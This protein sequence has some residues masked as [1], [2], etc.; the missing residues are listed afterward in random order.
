M[1]LNAK[2]ADHHLTRHACIYIRQSTMAQVRF[3]QE[4]TERQY[5]LAD[6]AKSLGW[7][8]EQIRILDGDL[9]QSG[10]QTTKRDDFKTLVTDVAMGQ[11][12]AIF[13]LE[14]SRLARS[15][16]DWHRLLELCAITK[17]LVFDGDGCYDP[18][19][20]NDSLVLGMKGTFAQAELHIIRARL[21]GG[22]L[23]K[24]HKGELRFPLPVGLVFDGDKIVLDPDQEVQGAVRAAF[25]LFEQ[26][27]SAYGV[28]QRFHQLGLL[29]PRR[30]YGGVWNGKLIWGRLTHSR[31]LGVLTN[32]SY[33]GTYVFGRYQ[34]CKKIGPAGEISTQSRQMPQDQ[35]RVVIPDHHPGYITWAQFLANRSHL[36]A[37]RTNSEV[38][39]GPAREGLCLLQGVLL[40]GICG[41]RLSTRY[42]GNGG[43]YP[44]YDCN[45]RSRD[46]SPLRHCMS[47]PAKPL[48]DAIAARLLTAVTPLTIK[49]ALEALNNLEVR[50]KTISAQWRR[51]I[52]RARYEA[53]LAER[54]YEESDPS[55]RLVAATLEK[56]WNDA[57]Q[58]VIELEAELA[59]FERQSMRSVTAEQ[60]QQILRLGRDF[61]RLWKAPTT[62]ARDR[63]RILRLLIRD[64]TVSKA[65]QPKLL[66]LQ[67]CW[68]GG[69]TET[70]EVQQRPSYPDV[71]RYPDAFVAKIR[72]MAERYDDTEIVARLKAEGLTSSTGKLFTASMISWTRYKHRISR[73]LLPDGTLNVRQVRARYGVSLWVV[74]Y[75]I[76][77]G[78]VSATQRK[79]NAPYA[80]KI[81]DNVDQRLREWV[82]N[83]SHLHPACP[84]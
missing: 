84:T 51:R 37:N 40:C 45:S 27:N 14:S 33:A 38:L 68:Q 71:L 73:P 79:S 82:A 1:L 22:K 17:T 15:N 55:N 63:K 21:H 72:T 13:S 70:T 44:S 9:A 30:S 41:R 58:R 36:A 64:I 31:V 47:L 3:N 53:D 29:F 54:R 12:G 26:E 59:H 28:V 6:Q 46:A 25:E 49:L 81:D 39:A 4:S 35:W 65:P 67:I 61:P 50:D 43:L 62:S 34:S 32:P 74:H 2:I 18:S 60:K 19:D 57:M 24:A 66:R 8:P 77:R 76:E 5:N 7:S 16:K 20:F 52:E 10:Q 56:R 42:A 23:N 83:S 69:A 75:W 78:I 11:V 48:D 80:I